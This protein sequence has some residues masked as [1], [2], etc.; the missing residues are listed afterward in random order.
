MLKQG[1]YIRPS[2]D[3]DQAM[4]A[5]ILTENGEVLRRLTYR[6][7]APDE[8]ADKMGQMPKKSSWPESMKGWGPNTKRV[9]GHRA[10]EYPTV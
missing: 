10:R 1:L 2:I 9:G 4:T 6:P 7:L 3:V 8:S 5:K